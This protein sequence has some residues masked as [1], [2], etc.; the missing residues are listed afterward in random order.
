MSLSVAAGTVFGY[1]LDKQFKTSPTLTVV[2][3][4]AGLVAGIFT[5][6]KVWRFLKDKV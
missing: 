3:M 2:C 4:F 1:I 6:V 5:F